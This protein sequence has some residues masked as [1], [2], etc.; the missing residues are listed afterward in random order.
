MKSK[1]SNIMTYPTLRTLLGS[2]LTGRLALAAALFA[3]GSVAGNNELIY[4]VSDQTNQ[5]ISFDSST[6]GTLLSANNI[7]GLA[8]NEQLLGITWFNG[9]LYGLGSGSHL[10]TINPNTAVATPVGAQFSPTLNGS[11]FGFTAGTFSL[12]ESSDSGQNLTLNPLTGVAVAGPNLSP[13]VDAMA[14]NALNGDFYGIGAHNP[15][16]YGLDP[17]TG[18]TF[19]IGPTGVSFEDGI[20]FDISPSTGIAYVSG[21]VAGQTELFTGDLATGALSLIGDV[22]VPGE[23]S[24]GLDGI[25]VAPVAEPGTMSLWVCGCVSLFGLRR[26]RK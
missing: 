8:G 5:L 10:Y 11:D 25:A 17:V 13:A 20:G 2:R 18:A 21:T 23:F 12:Y 19:L 26:R 16:M 14:Y 22:G 3:A 9:T 6:P 4:G 15:D 1:I 7:S 24:S